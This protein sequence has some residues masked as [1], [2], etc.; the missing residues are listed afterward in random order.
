MLWLKTPHVVFLPVVFLGFSFGRLW[1]I[2]GMS[3]CTFLT[4]WPWPMTLTYE[5]DLDILPFDFHAKIQVR[6]SVRSAYRETKGHTH[7][8]MMS[9]L[10]HTLNRKSLTCFV[11]TKPRGSVVITNPLA[12]RMSQLGMSAE[13]L[14]LLL[15]T[16]FLCK[17]T[18]VLWLCKSKGFHN[19]FLRVHP[20]RQRCGLSWET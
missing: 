17:Y 15:L 16:V 14:T 2:N 11:R 7:R 9:K 13:E 8:H 18:K 5:L 10:L 6:T 19:S 1:E 20:S 12:S 4:L 3:Q